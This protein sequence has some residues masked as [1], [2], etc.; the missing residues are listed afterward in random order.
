MTI[1]G[2]VDNTLPRAGSGIAGLDAILRGGFPRD[3]MY[4]V[5][6]T[7]G[8][9]K[10]TFGLQCL[11]EGARLGERVMY[12]TLSES[13]EE[14]LQ[15]ASSHGWRLDGIEIFEYATEEDVAEAQQHTIFHSSEVDLTETIANILREVER[16]QPMRLVFD[17]LAELRLLAG[18]QLAYRREIL[19]LKRYF[20]RRGCTV[21]G[22]TL[23]PA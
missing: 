9:G 7:P 11:L 3:R 15:V 2:A 16:I 5:Q 13:R 19:S 18:G 12:V 10:T 21:I 14:L 17:S 1:S 6:G 22:M 23:T 8:V 4:L 20:A